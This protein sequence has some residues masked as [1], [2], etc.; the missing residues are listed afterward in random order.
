MYMFINVDVCVS[1]V[2]ILCSP[3]VEEIKIVSNL[4]C[5]GASVTGMS[6]HVQTSCSQPTS[7]VTLLHDISA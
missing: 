1:I 2:Y 7:F 3:M 4:L 6:T 5:G